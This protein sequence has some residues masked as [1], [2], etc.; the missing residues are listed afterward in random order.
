VAAAA[1]G[2]AQFRMAGKREAGAMSEMKEKGPD[3]ARVFSPPPLLFAG[4]IAA[5]ILLDGASPDRSG[6]LGWP[7]LAGYAFALAG[8]A[9]IAASL[10]LFR[11]HRTRPEPWQPAAALIQSGIYL[12]SRNPMYL[13]M[14]CLS[15]GFCIFFESIVAVLLVAAVAIFIDRFVIAREEAYLSRRFGADYDR[16]KRQV[17]RWL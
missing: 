4:A 6:F 9:L 15:L 17:R 5:G 11:R 8:A 13:G 12:Y 16:Y 7:Q 10:G 2:A 3:S 1:H 14:A